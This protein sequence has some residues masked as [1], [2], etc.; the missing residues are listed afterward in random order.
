VAVTSPPSPRS[1][2][3]RFAGLARSLRVAT[4]LTAVA[5]LT[6]TLVGGDVGTV[7]GVVVVVLVVA[8]P[9][10][11]VAWLG[12]RWYRRG[13]RRFAAAAAALLGVVAAAAV[14]ALVGPS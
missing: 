11:R 3:Q 5:A 9:V 6:G 7:A 8:A 14:L 13:D 2:E 1:P 10:V 4:V 12:A